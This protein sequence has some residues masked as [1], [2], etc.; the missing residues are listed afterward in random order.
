[1]LT[2]HYDY[3]FKVSLMVVGAVDIERLTVKSILSTF[4]LSDAKDNKSAKIFVTVR[5]NTP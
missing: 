4:Y 2:I 1:M 5:P 3:G